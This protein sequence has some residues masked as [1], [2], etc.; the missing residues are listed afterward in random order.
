MPER[1]RRASERATRIRTVTIVISP[2]RLARQLD[3]ALRRDGT[4][5]RL[6]R[7]GGRL[8]LSID[9][10]VPERYRRAHGG[11][12]SRPMKLNTFARLAIAVRADDGSAFHGGAARPAR[13]G[14]ATADQPVAGSDIGELQVPIDRSRQHG[15]THR[16]H[17]RLRER[18]QHHLSRLRGRRRV[19]VGEQRHD[20]SSR[21]SRPTAPASI[22]DIAIHPHEPEHR[23][24]RHRRAEQPADLVVRRRHLQD[25]RRRQDVHATSDC[26]RRSR[27]RAS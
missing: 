10:A 16:R 12:E 3:N 22:G 7:E 2:V 27:S 20:A 1:R 19:Q 9:R 6:R 21:C 11:V 14:G 13:A 15:R 4:P 17:R 18:P 26:K 8:M 5:K 25:D 24:R 23:L